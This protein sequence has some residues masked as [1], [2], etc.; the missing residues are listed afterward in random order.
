MAQCPSIG[1]TVV[2][3]VRLRSGHGTG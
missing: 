1:S 3:E 2:D